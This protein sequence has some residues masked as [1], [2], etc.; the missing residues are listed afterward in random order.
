MHTVD[1]NN[2]RYMPRHQEI[3]KFS[4]IFDVPGPQKV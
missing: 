3:A 4:R 1:C 2:I